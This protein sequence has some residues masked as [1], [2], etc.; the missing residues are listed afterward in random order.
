MATASLLPTSRGQA[1]K[2]AIREGALRDEAPPFVLSH[3]FSTGARRNPATP[4][5]GTDDQDRRPHHIGH[6]GT[7]YRPHRLMCSWRSGFPDS[8]A[9]IDAMTDQGPDGRRIPANRA[10]GGLLA[11]APQ[12][13]RT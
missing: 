5:T 13:R 4:G 8:D 1:R 6:A 10:L 2:P 9:H 11:S 12:G 3:M 7:K